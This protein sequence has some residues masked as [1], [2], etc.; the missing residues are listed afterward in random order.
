M[1]KVDPIKCNGDELCVALCPAGAAEMDGGSGKA[2]IDVD[3]CLEC[4]ACRDSCPQE[5]ISEEEE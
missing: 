3:A 5:A 2:L 4:Y 1:L